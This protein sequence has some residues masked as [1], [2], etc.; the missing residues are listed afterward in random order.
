MKNIKKIVAATMCGAMALTMTACSGGKLSERLEDF[1]EDANIEYADNYY[2]ND[3]TRY[4]IAENEKEIKSTV[5]DFHLDVDDYDFDTVIK[6]RY[7]DLT[8][9]GS[10]FVFTNDDDAEDFYEDLVDYKADDEGI[11]HKAFTCVVDDE[12]YT[13]VTYGSADGRIRVNSIDCIYIK[14][15][16]VFY[17]YCCDYQAYSDG[18]AEMIDEMNL[19]NPVDVDWASEVEDML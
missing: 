7:G 3:S 12:D 15:N 17:T 19:E 11:S 1:C 2:S 18:F 9:G 4:S 5:S 6:F 8:V 14:D 16:E 13:F 10:C